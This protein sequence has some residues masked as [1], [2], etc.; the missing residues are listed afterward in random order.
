MEV[1]KFMGDAQSLG[2]KCLPGAFN[3]LGILYNSVFGDGKLHDGIHVKNTVFICGCREGDVFI[4]KG[5]QFVLT[6][7]EVGG[8][9]C[10]D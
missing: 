1:G 3:Y 4:D 2:V 6:A 9:F 5:S 8:G 7:G 10:P